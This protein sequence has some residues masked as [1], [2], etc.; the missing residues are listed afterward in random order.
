MD[1]AEILRIVRT[2]LS[3]HCYEMAKLLL[4]NSEVRM[5]TEVPVQISVKKIL[6]TIQVQEYSS[7]KAGLNICGIVELIDAMLDLDADD[8]VLKYGFMSP[9]FVGDFY[10]LEGQDYFVGARIVEKKCN[11]PRN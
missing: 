11:L 7:R 4:M 5:A 8:V 9:F 3:S 1:N 2:K 6:P 10:F